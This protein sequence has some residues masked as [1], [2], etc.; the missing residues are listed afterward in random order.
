V[1]DGTI[2][3]RDRAGAR[4]EAGCR[5]CVGA[6]RA[7]AGWCVRTDRAEA[8][9][10]VITR[11]VG[12]R[13][14]GADSASTGWGRQRASCV[15][16]LAGSRDRA[17]RV[18]AL[19]ASYDNIGHIEIWGTR[20][21]VECGQVEL[22]IIV[23]VSGRFQNGSRA[24]H[25]PVSWYD[26]ALLHGSSLRG[27]S[28]HNTET[29]EQMKIDVAVQNPRAS[30]VGDESE[31]D[32]GLLRLRTHRHGVPF[33][34]IHEIRGTVRR[35]ANHMESV[36]VQVDAMRSTNSA[37]RVKVGSWHIDLDDLVLG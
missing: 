11:R 7:E 34:W 25:S 15:G 35:S 1:N 6:G 26:T 36:P 14:T 8:G 12:P 24:K 32:V 30:I 33:H 18:W 21:D 22:A 17:G 31:S 27:L 23:E 28:H 19:A 5:Q 37:S 3:R 9:W 16:A 2:G 29:T 10:C 4:I 20:R 13:R